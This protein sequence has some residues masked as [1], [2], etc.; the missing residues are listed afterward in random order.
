MVRTIKRGE[1][2]RKNRIF[3]RTV[4]II[5]ALLLSGIFI[6]S[7]G[8]NPLEVF[9]SMVKGAFGSPHRIRETIV[10]AIPLIITAI[11]I[12]IA[13]KMQFWNIGGDGQMFIGAFGA[14]LVALKMPSFPM[15]VTIILMIFIGGVLGGL[16]AMI[17]GVLKVYFNTNETIVTLMLNYIAMKFVTYLQYGPWKDAEAQGFAKI[18][19]F[20]DN[21]IMPQLFGVHIGWI[22]A[23]IFIG[24]FYILMNRSKMGY[25]IAVLGESENTAKYAGIHINK[26]ILRAVFISG[27][28]CG[29]A[30]VIQAS[31][32]SQTLSV[33]VSGGMGYTAIIVAWLSNLSTPIIGI[34]SIL[35]AALLEGGS[36]IETAFGIPNAG[37]L[38]IQALI[39]FCI[40]GSEFFIK[41]KV[42]FK[43]VKEA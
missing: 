9:A 30:G 2:T 14:A 18:A 20:P 26:T 38:V 39:L 35:F 36:F 41:Y 19:N 10:K 15:P 40:L 5:I 42:T 3:I 13:F 12:S 1:I 22:I 29:I 23:L 21:A 11:G 4:A 28:I 24:I 17:A 27:T 8:H 34:V 33:E 25:E 31:A 16:W 7:L 43:N 32:V 37:A 6:L